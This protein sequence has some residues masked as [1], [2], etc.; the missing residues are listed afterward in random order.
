M[1]TN[2]NPN[3]AIPMYKQVINIISDQIAGGEFKPGDK[4]PSELELMQRFGVSRITIRAAIAELVDDGILTRAQGK[5]T[6]V[7]SPKINHPAL[8]LLG[9]H[10]SCT[11]AGKTGTTKLIN[12]AWI[13]PT[14]KQKDF[15]N[16]GEQDMV[17]CTKRLRYVDDV[18]TMIEINHY[19]EEFSYL[20]Q[21]DLNQSLFSIFKKHNYQFS[22]TERTLEICK[23]NEEEGKLLQ[24]K[25][26]TPLLLFQD[27]HNDSEG[28]ASFLS[29][30]I[31]H[32]QNLKFYF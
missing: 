28:K 31:Y 14:Q 25:P 10:R 27:T 11:L 1:P 3:S 20:F 22:V 19:P 16:L 13:A 9:F 32:T 4:I 6:F 15:W 8:D 17:I 26:N 12:I 2:I 30:Q 23:A 18:P 7:A 5:G 29:K 21:E 24:I